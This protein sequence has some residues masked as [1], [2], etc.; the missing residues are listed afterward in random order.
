[1]SNEND[2]HHEDASEEDLIP[3]RMLNELVY[4]PRLFYLE[5]VAGEWDDSADTL[6]GQRVHKRVDAKTTALPAGDELPDAPF[7]A[8]SVTVASATEGIVAKTDLV[9]AEGGAV[10]PVDYKRGSAPDPDRVPGGAWPADRVQAAA[11]ALALRDSGYRCDHAEIYYAASKQR[12]RVELDE[13]QVA[14][15]R[16][17]VADARRVRA[18]PVAPPPLVASPK[19]PRCSLVGICLPDE[20]TSLLAGPA[21]PAPGPAQ[22]SQ[23]ERAPL[24][25]LIPA[26]DDKTPLYVQAHGAQIGRNG[27]CLEIRQ[28]GGAVSTVRLREVSQVSVF[29]SVAVTPAALQELCSRGIDVALFGYGGWHYGT[30]GGFA[31]K[32][33]LLRIAQFAAAARPEARLAVAREIVAGKVFN[34]RTLLRRN[35]EEGSRGVLV[36]LKQLAARALEAASEEEL[37]GIEGSAARA[38]FAAFAGLLAPRSGEQTAF[39]FARRNRRPPRDP[40]NAL[41]SL[42]Y[43]LLA[44]DAR[45][46]L[47]SVG[48]DPTVGLYH[49]PRHGRPALALDLME[50]FRPLVVD[51]T[52][53]SAVNT[54]VVREEH[55]V[56]AA[57]G[58]ALTDAGRKAFLGAY[59]RRM[60]QEVNHPLFGYVVSYR[61]VL[62]VQARL[63]SRVVLGE[64]DRYPSFR[65]R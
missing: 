60:D 50:E 62:E 9:E 8:R 53:L 1:M 5:H 32:N 47:L 17:A 45:V 29:G 41:L 57:G 52:V 64:L 18:L 55:F 25:R 38:Y 27:E 11:Q 65:T 56:R 19:C 40:V 24:R 21:P 34:G 16:S 43:A 7:R 54:E 46:A 10:V 58:C 2:A 23:A 14:E 6:Q 63:L 26:R 36:D 44:K 13:A 51:S 22:A 4:C 48:F 49:R 31:E 37:L 61:R 39:D 30:V 20:V 12:V 15:V 3:A 33:V 35:A 59:E 42:G 28:K